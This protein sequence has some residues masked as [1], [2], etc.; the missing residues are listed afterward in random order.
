MGKIL[1]ISAFYHD[2]AAAVVVDGAIV[3]AAQEERFTRKKHDPS[4]PANAVRHV[5][6][7]A[8]LR[9]SDLDG[10]VFYDKPMVKFERLLE[11]FVSCSPAGCG[12]FIKAMPVWA[13]EK[14]FQKKVISD[15]LIRL[16]GLG[17][18]D[19]PPLMFTEH[20]HSHAASAYFPSP[21]ESAAVLCLDGVGEWATT[22]A[23]LGKGLDLKPLWRIDFPHSLG[24]L[25]SAFT[26]YCGFRVNSGEY[27]LMGLAPYGIPRY[28]DRI[29]EK[30]IDVRK[31]GTFRLNMEFFEFP[32]GSAMTG[33]AFNDLFGQPV[34]DSESPIEKFHADVAASIQSVL[35]EV[36]MRMSGALLE[37][38]GQGN[39]CLAGGVALNCVAN[40][41][42]A[43]LPQVKNIWIQ[44]ASGDA[45]GA[46]GAALA[47]DIQ[48]NRSPRMH[49]DNN[50]S[51]NDG[52][53][54]ALLGPSQSE[55]EIEDELLRC[56]AVF[57]EMDSTHLVL[58]TA[59]ALASEKIVGWV[60][61]RMEFGPRALGNRSILGDARSAKMQSWMNRKI[62]FR[63]GFRP[64]APVVTDSHAEDYFEMPTEVSP[65]ML[66]TGKVRGFTGS[67]WNPGRAM[68]KLAPPVV[69]SPLPAV[70]H[71]NGSA[72]VQTVDSRTN[73]MLFKLLNAFEGRTGIPVLVNT[74]FNIR[75]E[76]IV[77]TAGDAFRCFINTHMDVLVVGRF[78]MRKSDQIVCADIE[79]WKERFPLD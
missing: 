20:H 17:K 12:M 8:R 77:C 41:R 30:L 33:R 70:T 1:G 31:D 35:E 66:L 73:P 21:F 36:V 69:E 23:W 26:Y 58:E 32:V 16:S 48:K 2:S 52:M 49:L 28:A 10:V 22:T 4:F 9:L 6:E 7:M 15:Q 24:L 60:Q 56:G 25:Y 18:S 75:G 64:F 68:G 67:E 65:Y 78:F 46:L 3:A 53:Q 34:R 55:R 40:S 71:V 54:G 63:E 61:G 29:R 76:P 79:S 37:E 62:K 50:H 38:T 13:G 57:Q 44:P 45:G 11:T 72:R 43:R 39:L 74:S 27:K 59:E 19:L 51:K 14:L 47:V 5:L 42:I